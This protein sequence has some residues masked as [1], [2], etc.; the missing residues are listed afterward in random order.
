M[1][2]FVILMITT[3]GWKGSVYEHE[4][5]VPSGVVERNGKSLI[6]I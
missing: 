2:A 6:M 3:M 1:L 5:G 4:K